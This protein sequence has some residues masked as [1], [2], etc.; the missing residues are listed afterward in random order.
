MCKK[1]DGW[2]WCVAGLTVWFG[3]SALG[4]DSVRAL[5]AATVV[6]QGA[7]TTG[8]A[9]PVAEERWI[10]RRGSAAVSF[11]LPAIGKHG[12]RIGEID[13]IGSA[14]LGDSVQWA[15]GINPDSTLTFSVVENSLSEF[16]GGEILLIGKLGLIVGDAEYSLDELSI[17]PAGGDPP[18]ALWLAEPAG[19]ENPG[20]RMHRV[21]TGFDP[22]TQMLTLRS[23]ELH[24]SPEL[25]QIMGDPELVNVV[26]GSMTIRAKAEWVGGVQPE[27][28]VGDD[29]VDEASGSRTASGN[30]F[31]GPDMTFCQLYGLGQY[32]RSGDIVGLS[33]ATTSWNV[34]DQDLM[35]FNIPDE[36]H[37]YIV[38]NL[39]RLKDDRFEQ[40]GQSHIKHG[41]YALGSHQC[42]GPSCT[43]ES[44]HGPGDWLGTGCTDTY[45][46]GLN[47]SQSGL[48][49]KYEVDPWAGYWYYPGSHMQGS[50]GHDG[51]IN[52]R[53]QVHDSDLNP[54]QNPD[55]TYY[56]EGYYVVLDD[57]NAMNS[58]AWK[59]VTITSGAPGGTWY[60]GMSGSGTFPNTGYALDAW[61]G[62][63]QTILAQQIPVIEFVSPDGRCQLGAKA[64][65]LGD[66][67]WHYEYAL[68]NIDMDRQVGSFS[69]PIPAN[70]EVSN[71]EF[72]AAEHHGEPVNTAD[73][74]AV[75]ID[76]APWTIAV[77]ADA[78]TW[79]TTTNPVRWGTLYN[80]RFDADVSPGDAVVSLGMFRAGIPAEV[81]GLTVGPLLACP[82]TTPDLDGDGD[83]DAADLAQ[84]LGSWGPCV[85]CPADFDVDGT[86]GAS[87]LAILLGA[88]GPV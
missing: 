53:L 5:P 70:T 50:H 61:T 35:W 39:F 72:H 87:D 26:I 13:G 83:V 49:P 57:V 3:V 24:V 76:N 23:P 69:I 12:L 31:R 59:E 65:D 11:D 25:A 62:A 29:I 32:G 60:F 18:L 54:P 73:D 38:M 52:H 74:D 68:L 30:L 86:V 17:T 66:G 1:T 77:S 40:I 34:G 33:V 28:G 75:P 27:I 56:S 48:G 7:S 41:F 45:G 19:T 2:V 43:Y 51:Q 82:P 67:Q 36:E 6:E 78:V 8:S 63:Q 84:L 81:T 46:A 14:L 37:P 64:T 42:G 79:S 88:W 80:F 4:A 85:C 9:F 58:A 20:L 10:V 44:G 71:V 55:A 47:A 15:F 16:L 21:K 22:A